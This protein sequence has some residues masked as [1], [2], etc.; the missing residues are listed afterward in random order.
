MILL[1]LIDNIKLISMNKNVFSVMIFVFF[2]KENIY[3][4]TFYTH[5][6]QSLK[7]L[8]IILK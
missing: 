2:I 7:N 1:Y 8:H 4:Y 3:L 5:I 6:A